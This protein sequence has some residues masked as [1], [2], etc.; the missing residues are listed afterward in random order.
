MFTVHLSQI[1]FFT[2]V[3]QLLEIFTQLYNTIIDFYRELQLSAGYTVCLSVCL[4][5][6]LFVYVRTVSLI[7]TN[8]RLNCLSLL[9]RH[10]VTN[11]L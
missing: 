3:F 5:V 11:L 9:V 8:K 2:A 1:N 7:L 6:Y 4:T 10:S